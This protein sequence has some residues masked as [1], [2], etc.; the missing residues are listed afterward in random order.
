MIEVVGQMERSIKS[1]GL[2]GQVSFIGRTGGLPALN[3]SVLYSAVVI[4]RVV[5]AGSRRHFEELTSF[6]GMNTLR[7]IIDR[8]FSFEGARAAFPYFEAAKGFG[9]VVIIHD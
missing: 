2:D 6:S 1:T 9:K 5:F 8:S 4:V 3:L 7:P